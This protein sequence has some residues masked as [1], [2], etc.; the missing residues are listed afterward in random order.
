M[1]EQKQNLLVRIFRKYMSEESELETYQAVGVL[2]L[3]F[4]IAGCVGWVWE[5]IIKLIAG[6][7]SGFYITGGNLLPWINMYAYGAVLIILIAHKLKRKPIVIFGV[8][9]VAMGIFEL[10]GGWLVYVIG[11]GTRYWDYTNEWY[12]VGN[13]NGFVCPVSAMAFGLGALALV[14]GLVPFCA[15]LMN[16]MTKKAFLT[17][18]ISLFAVIVVDDVVNLGL[19]WSGLPSAMD[20]YS[21]IGFKGL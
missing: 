18:A 4:V 8:S 19:R 6:G 11:N 17:L 13:I 14:Y 1:V 12:A 3:V 5:F 2:L 15:R 10:I 21:S 9:T 7:F 20:F 16:R